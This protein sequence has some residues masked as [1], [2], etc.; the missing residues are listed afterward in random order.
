MSNL[1][2]SFSLAVKSLINRRW[3]AFLT[4]FSIAISVALLVGVNRVR[5]DTRDS[6]NNTI[7]STDLI[8]GAR[9]GDLNLLLYSVFRIGNAT[10][11]ISWESYE[12]V[13]SSDSVAWAI[14][15]SLGDAH[16][17]YRVLG[18]NNNYFQ[19]YRYG[20][21]R[22]L[23]F[24]EGQPFES[25]TD[26]VLGSE[27]ARELG[28]K[29]G[30]E[31]IVSHG[32]GATSFVQHDDDPFRVTGILNPTGTPVDKTVHVTLE[33]ID[34]MHDEHDS[35][36]AG[37][38]DHPAD[39]GDED[40]HHEAHDGDHGSDHGDEDDHHG[41]HDDD[42]GSDH[43]DEN[44]HHD[45]HD[46]DHGSD[47]GDE[48]DHHGEHDDD[49]GSDNGNEDGHHG[50]HDD[51]HGS[52]PTDEHDGHDHQ[53]EPNSIT[54]F[55]LGLKS[56]P[57]ALRMQRD[58]NEYTPEPMTAILPGV[59]LQQ[60]WG[61]VRVA[62]YAL[63][64]VSACVVLAGILGM[65]TS[66]LMSLNERRREMAILRSVGARPSY[67]FLLL[68][69]EASV[70]A[71]AGAVLGLILARVILFAASSWITGQYGIYLSVFT[72]GPFELVL[73]G[74]VILLSIIVSLIPAWRAYRN[75]LVDGLS[76][77]L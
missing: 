30:D 68:V 2:Q 28:Y 27:V 33:G 15:L 67:I 69:F 24:A 51:D 18:T 3:T 60:L 6:F 13:I 44:D 31:I 37:E 49:H 45:E 66:L 55:L 21:K 46:D 41:E 23:E 61:L 62:E 64:A 7:S 73:M 65:L 74:V 26:A 63:L 71:L 16:R 8:V 59:A 5:N 39:H 12:T 36:H 32:I 53:H 35:E 19:H 43:A 72:I 77:R 1:L 42:H 57:L 58:I 25:A 10:N 38:H 29:L 22:D 14:P 48:D 4:V 76:V 50:E 20:Q 11:N 47:H 75:T 52:D 17:G 34:L 9:S 70:L 40:D 56:R 54:A